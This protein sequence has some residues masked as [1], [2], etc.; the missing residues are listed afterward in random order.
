M[1]INNKIDDTNVVVIGRNTG[2]NNNKHGA[3]I[4]PSIIGPLCWKTDR[5]I[6]DSLPVKPSTEQQNALINRLSGLQFIFPCRDCR[7]HFGRLIKEDPL[8]IPFTRYDASR[9]LWRAYNNVNRRIGQP[10]VP[11]SEWM[12]E[13]HRWK[14]YRR[15]RVIFEDHDG[16]IKEFRSS[17]PAVI[18]YETN[19]MHQTMDMFYDT[20]RRPEVVASY[21][22][23]TV[24]SII[25]SVILLIIAVRAIM[26]KNVTREIE[27]RFDDDELHGL[28]KNNSLRHT[29]NTIIS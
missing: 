23:S 24:L 3:T 20:M 10:V 1:N 8:T 16:S 17:R 26:S 28:H 5:M 27:T 25:I 9:W 29:P 4:G 14:T 13:F 22:T 2:S 11:Y 15:S 6:I 21:I 19:S 7:F 12:S 18:K